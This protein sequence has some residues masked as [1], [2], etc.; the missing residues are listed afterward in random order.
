EDGLFPSKFSIDENNIEEERRL[1]YV[2]ITRAEDL[3]YLSSARSRRVFGSLMGSTKSRFINELEDT[4]EYEE[5]RSDYVS[6]VKSNPRDKSQNW[7]IDYMKYSIQERKENLQKQ[8]DE[9]YKLGDKVKH[10]K[11]GVGT[12]ITIEGN[13]LVISFEKAGLKKL[14][15]D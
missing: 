1:F 10:K 15:S 5:E 2:A 9:V 3:L 4:I 7:D 6:N 12:I 14:R 8:Q 13:E 11:F